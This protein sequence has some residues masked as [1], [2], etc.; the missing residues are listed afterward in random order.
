M[1]RLVFDLETDGLYRE[2]TKIHC[3]VVLDI[4]TMEGTYY[5]PSTIHKLPDQLKKA[6]GIIAHN[7]VG[8]DIPIIKKILGVDLYDY[9]VRKLDTLI[10]S[11]LIY[12]NGEFKKKHQANLEDH[13]R[14]LISHSLKA[15]GLRLGLL[16]GDYGEQ[17]DAWSRYTPE[18]LEYCKQDVQV[19][20]KLF[21]HL[22]SHPYR[23]DL[24]LEAIDLEHKF[25]R[26]IQEQTN[27]GWFFN[28]AKAQAL[29]VELFKEKE[30]IEKELEEVFKPIY[31]EGK[32][33]EYK[34]GSYKRK[35][36]VT[37]I[38]V[39]YYTHTPI[40]LTPF[41]PSSRQH[42]VKWLHRRYKWKPHK[43]TEKGSPIVDSSV[44]SKLKYPEAQL[45]CKYFDLQKVVGMLVEGKNGWLKLVNDESRI[46][47]ELDTLGA[48]SGRCTHRTPNLAQVPSSRAFK[49][50]ECRELFTVPTGKVL[51]GCDA[52]G[53]ELRMLAHYLYRYDGGEYADAVVDGDIHTTNQEAAGLDTRDQAKTFIYAFLYGAGDSKLGS[54]KGNTNM[55]KNGKELKAK[56]FKAIPAIEE[57]LEQVKVTAEKGYIRG[58]TGRRLHIRSPHSA[59]NT[60]LQ[61]AGAYV[62]K[63]YTVALYEA[64]SKYKDKVL[65]VGNIHDEVQLEV[66]E[67]IKEE[68]RVICEDIFKDI[69]TLLKFKVPL[70]GEA[71]IGITWNDTH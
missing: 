42:I 19:T 30:E 31:F 14:L 62:M 71:R 63:Y 69:T 61:S 37:G 1:T 41:N 49:G 50:K 60:L 56:F 25:A 11:K 57:L 54:I 26:V 66:S 3:A 48:V 68:V 13:K 52:S 29:H 64:L 15:W 55:A 20:A 59:L 36:E 65:F 2:C 32:L 22:Q 51:I 35:C 34:K 44:L 58:V 46:N 5:T 53:L 33:K 43:H 47:G 27:N 9:P 21:M 24:P 70:E 10:L 8:F 18:M 17:E 12:Y 6:D 23:P 45:L 40:A 16:K 28:I 39:E 7:G 38:K 67:D 4:D